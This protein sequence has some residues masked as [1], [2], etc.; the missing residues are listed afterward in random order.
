VRPD[1]AAFRELETLVRNL[2]EQ[3]AGF[4]RRALAAETRTRELEQIVAGMN[5]KLDELREQAEDMQQSRDAALLEARTMEAQVTGLRRELTRAQ[6]AGP[7]GGAVAGV[8]ALPVVAAAN[9]G[10]PRLVASRGD[11][12]LALREENEQLRGRL[13]E[14]RERTTRLGERVRFLRQQV[15][16][17]VER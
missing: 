12:D 6:S 17:G 11:D 1:V 9:D 7:A 10:V 8:T 16:L 2:S 5:G 3:L 15:S 4:R 14:A 13:A